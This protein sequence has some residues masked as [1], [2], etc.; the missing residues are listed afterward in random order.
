MDKVQ[1]IVARRSL[2]FDVPKWKPSFD[3]TFIFTFLNLLQTIRNKP[4]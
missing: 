1:R 2:L 3:S 4:L